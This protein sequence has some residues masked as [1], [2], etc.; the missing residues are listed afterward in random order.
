MASLMDFSINDSLKTYL[1]DPATTSTPDADPAL[2]ECES[3]PDALTG[4]LVNDVLNPIV[5][6]VAE[7]HDAITSRSTFDS[8][9]F[10]LKCAPTSLKSHQNYVRVPD[11]ELFALSRSTSLIPVN[12]LSKILDLVVSGLA[13]ASDVIHNDFEGDDQDAIHHHKR[14]L[15][16]YGFLL[17]WSL[18]AVETK[19]AETA[20]TATTHRGRGA[21]KTTKS[22]SSGKDA[23]WDPTSQLQTALEVMCRVLKL[24]ISNMFLTTSERDTFVNL[25]TRPVYLMLENEQRVKTTTLRMHAFK[26]LCIAVKHHGHAFGTK[27]ASGLRCGARLTGTYSGADLNHAESFVL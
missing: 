13:A 3:D 17:Q 11:A 20:A 4:Q 15:E 16:M 22:K 21:G 26:A 27:V 5:D 8:L 7:S 23:T 25:V 24:K 10:L 2:L 18:A 9:Q 14:L 6:A 12:S 1:S 19:A